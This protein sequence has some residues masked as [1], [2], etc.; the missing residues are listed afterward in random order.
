MATK[1]EL[2]I[3]VLQKLGVLYSGQTPTAADQTLVDEEYESV[4]EELRSRHLVT[5]GSAEDIPTWAVIHVRNIVAN[6]AANYFE[7]PRSMDEESVAFAAMSKH[8]ANDPSY[9]PIEADYY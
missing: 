3:K 9:E 7:R 8:I 1:T 2:G 5:W 4:Y 6:R